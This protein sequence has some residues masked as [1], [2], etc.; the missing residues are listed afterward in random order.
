MPIL[1]YNEFSLGVSSTLNPHLSSYVGFHTAL[2]INVFP[3]NLLIDLSNK[4]TLSSLPTTTSLISLLYRIG[5]GT[6][7]AFSIIISAA[8]RE[9]SSLIYLGRDL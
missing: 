7:V 2:Y 9:V 4:H 3:T 6:P 5:T 8:Y 1:I